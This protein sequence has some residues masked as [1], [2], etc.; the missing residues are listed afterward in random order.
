M[1]VIKKSILDI[2]FDP[3]NVRKHSKKNV[4]AIKASLAR[5]GQ[6]K[7]IVLDSRDIVRAGNGTLEAAKELGWKEIDCVYS[8]LEGSEMTAFAIADNRTAELA[9]WDN[10]NLGLQLESFDEELRQIVFEDYDFKELDFKADLP[11]EDD[12]E[13]GSDGP[14]TVIIECKD[15]DE[16]QMIFLE[17]RDRE[18]SVKVK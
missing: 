5:F 7:P 16:Q 9:E 10:E 6:Q 11:S 18:F 13:T 8:D 3:A 2:N 17:L 1:K 4:D 12:A 15:E 14:L